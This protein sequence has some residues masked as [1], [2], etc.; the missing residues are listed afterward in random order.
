M[1][2]LETT[3]LKNL[4]SDEEYTRKVVPFLKSD[5]FHDRSERLLFEQI[6]SFITKY[7][8]LPTT[9][10]LII[11]LDKNADVS[12]EDFSSAQTIL[13]ELNEIE[14]NKTWLIDQTEKFC[15]DKAIYN[16]VMNSIQILDGKTKQSKE[17]I[18]DFLENFL[19]FFLNLIVSFL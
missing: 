1:E 12:E 4:L 9:E 3:I 16:A 15:Q 5:Y 10:I 8:N 18:P 19:H 7:N 14:V 11:E 13:A 17:N 6:E 2:R